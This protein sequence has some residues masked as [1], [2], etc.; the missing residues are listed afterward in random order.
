MTN[1][2]YIWEETTKLVIANPEIGQ[3]LGAQLKLAHVQGSAGGALYLAVSQEFTKKLLDEP[4]RGPILSAFEKIPEAAGLEDFIV[5]VDSSLDTA[6]TS[7]VTGSGVGYNSGKQQ[8]DASGSAASESV[9]PDSWEPVDSD[10]APGGFNGAGYSSNA[11]G[12]WGDASMTGV[13][14][15]QH[16]SGGIGSVNQ[17]TML[18]P[19]LT[20]DSFVIAR[21]NRFSHAASVAVAEAPGRAYLPLFIYGSSGLGK[22]HLLHAIGNEALQ[23]HPGIKVRYVSSEEFTNDFINSIAANKGQEFHERWRQVDILL[24]DDI[25]FLSRK[26]ETLEAFFH[27]FN[28][29]QSQYKQI[30]ITS[31]VQPQHL[32]NIEE[33]LLSRFKMGLLTDIEAPDLE[34][35]IAILRA[36][37]K[38]ENLELSDDVLE[39]IAKKFTNNI[40]EL[41]GALVRITAY[42]NLNDAEIDLDLVYTVLK[43]VLPSDAETEIRPQD[44]IELTAD[45][46]RIS[47]EEIRGKSRS[48]QI[49]KPRQIA[50]Y[51]CRELTQLSLPKIGQLFNDR[52]HTTVLH[53]TRKIDSEIK[54]DHATYNDVAELTARLRKLGRPISRNR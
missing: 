11:A 54:K 42:A 6:A 45:Y 13:L 32:E 46:F 39:F 37:A 51:L 35:R 7:A 8:T 49:A 41:E 36:K 9:A 19:R 40:R 26:K 30:V 47:V 17:E 34:T 4:L 27:I 3:T 23:Q 28:T 33:R 16:T 10:S 2:K 31:D 12:V 5:L 18:N 44:I 38:R 48:Q 53:A 1:E 15:V 21:S 22:T 25:Q 24:I 14:P 52:D 29:L 43:D 50:M 20:F